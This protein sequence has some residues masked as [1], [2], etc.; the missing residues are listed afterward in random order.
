[1]PIDSSI[2]LSGRPVQFDNPMD[3]QGKAMSLRALAGQQQMQQMQ[4]QQ[5]QQ[6]QDQDRTLADLYRG[7]VNP[8]G[9]IN[10]QGVL[11]GAADNGLGAKIPTLQKQFLDAD[12]AQVKVGKLKSEA[13]EIDLNVTRKRMEL[14]AGALQALLAKPNVTHEDVIGTMAGLVQQGIVTP[15]QGQQAIR[16]LPGNPAQLR[17]YLM[18]QGIAVMDAKSRLDALTPKFDKVNNGKVTSFVD[19]NAI[20]NP[21]G[22]A[23]IRMTTTPGEDQSAATQRRGQNMTD[24]RAREANQ[25]TREANATTY[26][27]ERGMLVNRA[28]GLARPA[29]TMDG[30]PLG[31]KP[32][33]LTDA[34]AKALL[35]GTRMQEADVVLNKLATQGTDRPSLIKSGVERTPLI[36]GALGAVANS[37]VAS[38]AQQQVEQAQRDFINAVL[39]RESGAVITDSE[40]DNARKQYFPQVGD[41]PAVKQQ[42]QQNRQRARELMLEEVPNARR[43]G[44]ATPHASTPVTMPAA[45][46][47]QLPADIQ[48]ILNKHGAK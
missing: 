9:T 16:Q 12:E 27:T 17:Q 26:D 40:F 41:S 21:G 4:L 13:G 11:R 1:M 18:Q 28:T 33:D 43:T 10:R 39:R 46:D 24:A 23:D 34:Q 42:K 48:A 29:A 31:A 19:T 5:A 47:F 44:G 7:N 30:K 45:V 38:P 22:P 14:S 6:Q 2:A 36:G 15:E 3:I 32:K 35:F 20:T 25:L 37:T 8:D